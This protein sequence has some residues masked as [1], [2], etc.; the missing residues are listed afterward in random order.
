V[1]SLGTRGL[2]ASFT[3]FRILSLSPPNS[4]DAAEPLDSLVVDK[5][6]GWKCA[7]VEGPLHLTAAVQG[8]RQTILFHR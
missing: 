6:L 5:N 3:C 8:Q 4:P 2:A 7:H 1:N